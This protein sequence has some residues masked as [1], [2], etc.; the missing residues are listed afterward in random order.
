VKHPFRSR[1]GAAHGRQVT[2]APARADDLAELVLKDL[3]GRDARLGDTW[4]D[5]PVALV[6]LRHYG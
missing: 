4:R 5:G 6:W 2:R 3:D 1:L